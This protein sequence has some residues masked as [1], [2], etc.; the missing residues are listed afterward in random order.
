VQRY[1]YLV[2]RSL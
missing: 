2:N 1:S